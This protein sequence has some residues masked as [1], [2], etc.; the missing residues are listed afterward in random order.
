MLKIVATVAALG[1]AGW[2]YFIGGAKLD[3][4]LIRQFYADQ[5]HAT[6]SRDAEALCKQY[7]KKLSMKQEILTM[8][9][10]Q[11]GTY[12]RKEAC[13]AQR[14]TFKTF[15]ELGERAGGILTIDYE[16]QIE[17][18]DIAPNKKSALVQVS[19]QLKMG[20]TFMQFKHVSTDE[21]VREFGTVY[22]LKAQTQ[23]KARI[24]MGGLM[25]PEKFFKA[26]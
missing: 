20:D 7:A 9:Q 13:E 17:R 19:S 25:D 24:H 15:E 3:E 22:L 11:I 6:L 8:G 23:S 5:A 10:S 12:G 4:A 16:Y 14:N 2:Y 21:L 1:V 26:Q 18:I